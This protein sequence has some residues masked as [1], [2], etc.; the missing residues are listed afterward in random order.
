MSKVLL[1]SFISFIY[2]NLYAPYCHTQLSQT[3]RYLL[4][5]KKYVIISKYHIYTITALAKRHFR[6]LANTVSNFTVQQFELYGNTVAVYYLKN[7]TKQK[8]SR[9]S[10][11]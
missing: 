9:F 11:V 3:Y 5:N 8:D 1:E 10:V 4:K 2:E 6:D 7:K